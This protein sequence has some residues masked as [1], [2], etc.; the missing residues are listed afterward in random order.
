M[1]E[2]M[3]S[4]IV[5]V[6]HVRAYPGMALILSLGLTWLCVRVLPILNHYFGESITVTGL[7]T[8]GDLVEQT[9]E[10][11]ADA[12]LIARNM[13]R[14]EG[15]LFLD[16]MTLAEARAALRSPLRVVDNTGEALWRTIS[17]LEGW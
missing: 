6:L 12:V 8:G 13:L 10:I 4:E 1:N 3:M 5:A 14:A 16:D 9:R 15:D 2:N 7:I 11:E 17:G